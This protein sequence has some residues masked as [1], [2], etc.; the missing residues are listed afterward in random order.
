MSFEKFLSTNKL[1]YQP[2][3]FIV[4][5]GLQSIHKYKTNKKVPIRVRET[6]ATLSLS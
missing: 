3:K 5:N 2:S 6:T 4:W 1:Q